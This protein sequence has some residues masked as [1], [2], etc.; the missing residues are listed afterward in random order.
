MS[1]ADRGE[2]IDPGHPALSPTRPLFID[3]RDGNTLDR[4]LVQH[5]QTLRSETALP[6]EVCVA[7]AFFTVPGFNLLA[8]ELGNMGHV[9]LMLGADPLPEAARQPR[10]P[11]DPN[12][13]AFTR[14]LVGEA[15]KN[16]DA[17][18]ARARDLL[19]FDEP[20]D[21]AVRRLLTM[22]YARG[23][24]QQPK[25]EVR[26][27]EEQFLHAKAFIFRVVGG[28]T[29][30]GSSNLTYGGLRGNLE[31]NLGHYEDPVVGKVETW[32]DELWDK[33]APFDLAAIFDR[34]MAEYPPYLIYLR[35]LYA[36]Y[37]KE[38]EEETEELREIGEIP[39]TT[40]QQH[41]VWRA[42]RI[43]KEHGGVLV[44]DGVGLGKTFIAGEVI[45][46]YQLRRQPVL[47]VCPASLR[48]STW[49]QF[50]H[51]YDFRRSVECVSYEQLAREQQ[52]G[53]DQ[54]EMNRPIDEFALV[55]V[56]EAHNYRNPDAPARAQILR[57][58][59]M[60]RRR[61]L[62]LMS[63]TPV[64][65]SLWDLYHVLRYF[66]KQDAILAKRGVLSIRERFDDA[67]REDPFNLNPDL[68][69]PIIDATTVK[70]TRQFI[71]KHYENDLIKLPDGTSMQIKFPKPTASSITYDLD[72]VLPGFLAE[73]EAALMPPDGHPRL[74]MARYQPENYPGGE[75]HG[76]TDTALVGLLRS[77]LLKRFESSV[78]AFAETTGKMVREHDLFLR[79]LDQGVIV[80][81]E[82]L[83]EL[84]AADDEEVIDE[85]LGGSELRE[86]A[87]SYDVP[88]LRAAVEADRDLL[89]RM[90][91]KARRV[92]P[93]DD[94][95]LAALVEE[96]AKI[97]EQARKEAIDDDDQRRKQKILV[98]SF[99]EDTI[100]WIEGFLDRA[101]ENDK[102]LVCYRGR[103][104]SAAGGEGRGG[105]SRQD[106]IYGFAP[107]SSGAPPGR[108]QDRFDL[109]LST[110]VLA[111]GMNL[112]QCRNIINFDLPWNPMRLVQRHGRIDRIGSRHDRV[113]LR[114]Y[115]PDKQLDALLNLE[116]RVRRKLAQAAASVGV[117]VAPIERGAVGQQS[118]SE[119]RDEIERLQSGDASIYEAGG[120]AS[121]AQ[122]G[123]EYRQELRK[124]LV[125]QRAEVEGLPWKAGSGLAKG[126]RRG[127]FFCATVGDRVYLRFVP[128]S[129]YGSGAAIVTEIGTCLR[130]IECRED[131]PR[132]IPLDLKQTAFSAWQRARRHIHEAWTHE[133]DPANLQPRVSKLNR[134]VA[135]FLRQYTPRDVEQARLESCLDAVEAPCARREENLLRAV[136]EQEYPSFAAKSLAIVE[137]V[138]RIG[139][140][141]FA[142]PAPLPP[143]LPD[144][145]H[146]ICWMA[147]EQSGAS[148]S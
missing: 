128:F 92:K 97:A 146:L 129:G 62:L 46:R 136:F 91:Q 123:E 133:T 122:T 12:E 110:D 83:R 15:L 98:F 23:P 107:E 132:V 103:R 37:G 28:G 148:A 3:N 99:Y 22:L 82:L 114:T 117:E 76:D 121:A 102:R 65:N 145:V 139:L 32:F 130:M 29:V 134:E 143:I 118:F 72:G 116:E 27:Y 86:S 105:V 49:R 18:L 68:L 104:A 42:L 142:A 14:K 13:P 1:K 52:L 140:E 71:K 7:T 19:P 10:R 47:L 58:L 48:D 54:T 119:T 61:D 93:Q 59:L 120:T 43:L 5:L 31:L 50:L 11:G 44:A 94:P 138:E 20:T 87:E 75:P 69:Y 67:M 25:I 115:F 81:R 111:E 6:W 144:E 80:R 63:A 26:R 66:I 40:F 125:R 88:E 127:H 106:A 101:I 56:D 147:I 60:G 74:T 41:G 24:D 100:D 55:V 90:C 53:G 124:A 36:L 77:C 113:F 35:V 79:G 78:H 95:K 38:L 16:L 64:N 89:D 137:E 8:D 109:M 17:G 4:A 108:N 9:R 112:Q 135:E 33:A 21:A 34:L 30:V 126:Q 51:E 73:L 2:R 131:T 141:P 45:R 84:S 70:R 85:L 57:R 39:L 96:L